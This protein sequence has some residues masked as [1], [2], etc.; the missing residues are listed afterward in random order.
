MK[1]HTKKQL[2]RIRI[3]LIFESKKRTNYIVKHNIF[4]SVGKNFFFQPRI[5]PADP[6]LIKFH[7]NVTVASN[8][9][10]INHDLVHNV[11][12]NMNNGYYA[13]NSGC[14]EVMDNVFIGSNTTILPNVKIGP[15]AIIA[16]GSVVTKDVEENTIVAGVPAKVIGK[17]DE[18]IEK[19][20][21]KENL[22]SNQ[23]WDKFIKEK[24]IKND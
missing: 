15:N 22:N 13:Y 1:Q 9:T 3:A 6:E 19:R 11:L 10:F 8:V 14:I 23:L 12:N 17:F 4:K 2:K 5:I 16:A 20:K 21:N 24:G 7:N 18:Y